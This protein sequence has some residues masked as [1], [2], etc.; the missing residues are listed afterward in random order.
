MKAVI[1]YLRARLTMA[2]TALELREKWLREEQD[3]VEQAEILLAEAENFAQA[4]KCPDPGCLRPTREEIESEIDR[5][6]RAD[7]DAI[8]PAH[9]KENGHG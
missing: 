6:D 1:E 4:M 8:A 5:R 7:A 2:R 9:S 3:A